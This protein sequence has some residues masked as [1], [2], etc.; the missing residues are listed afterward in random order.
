M[1][2]FNRRHFLHQLAAGIAA[3]PLAFSPFGRALAATPAREDDRILVVFELSGGNDG[4]NTVVPYTNDHYYR[5]RP[6]LGIK[7]EKLLK[8]DDSWGFNPGMLG[9]KRLWDAGELG[10]V[11][12]C[13]YDEPSFSHFTS[14]AYWHTAAPNSGNDYGWVGRLADE[15]HPT[16]APGLIVNIDTVQSLA[17]KSRLHT[18]VVFDEPDRFQRNG[19]YESA[20]LLGASASDARENPALAY[21]NAVAASARD[22]SAKV[23]EAWHAYRSPVDY[24]I[25]PLQLPKIAACI[26]AGMP[27]RLYYAAFRNNAFDT[28]VQQADLHQRLLTYAA[29]ALH[30]F[31]RD[32][33]RI[34]AADRVTVLAFSEFGRRV[35]ENANLGTDHGTANVIFVMGKSVKAGHHGAP[36]ALD[37][38]NA[39]DNLAFTTDFRRVYASVIDGWLAPGVSPRVLG[40]DF[41]PLNLFV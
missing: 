36:P 27:S 24:G 39:D 11:H 17:V 25:V 34:G 32:L 21:L 14:M 33:E 28:H 26:A 9:F 35:P 31:M 23:R 16:P 20:S 5:H 18:P 3:S 2:H 41:E 13:G 37:V 8:L 22:S 1:R 30:G 6:T 19:F 12:G 15:L 10:I 29:D 4:L 38:L 7:P 40:G